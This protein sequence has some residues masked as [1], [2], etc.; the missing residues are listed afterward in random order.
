VSIAQ[1]TVPHWE[2]T[3]VRSEIVPNPTW[4][5]V[6]AAV[7]RLDNASLNDL[8]LQPDADNSETYLCVGGGGGRYVLAG[9]LAGDRFPTLVDP[10]RPA[11]PAELLRVGGQEG[12]YPANVVH[13]LETT[14]AAVQAFWASGSFDGA[15]LHWTEL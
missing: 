13:D 5:Q 14:L 4:E 8:Y 6:E 12:D 1:L 11:E 15:G 9:V 3:D 10:N 7:R 2:G